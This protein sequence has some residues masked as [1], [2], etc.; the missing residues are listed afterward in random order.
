[1]A[2]ST[3]TRFALTQQQMANW[4]G[5]ARSTVAA[6]EK[7]HRS[8]PLGGLESARLTVAAQGLTMMAPDGPWVVVPAQPVPLPDEKPLRRQL[9][10]CR[11][12]IA[13]LRHELDN[14]RQR[15]TGYEARFAALPALRAWGGVPSENPEREAH[16]L[17]HFEQEAVSELRY[18]CGPGPQRL[19]EARLAGLEREAE[20]LAEM[21]APPLP[22][23]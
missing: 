17:D 21:L 3:R 6:A 9:A 22:G 20:L 2:D 11:L 4:L 10:Q 8:L 7:G 1:M 15:A 13:A 18:V 14:L 12:R 5:I 19:L 16:W 23:A